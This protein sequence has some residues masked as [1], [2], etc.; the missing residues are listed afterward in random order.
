[1]VHARTNFARRR[2]GFTLIELILALFMASI[3]IVSLTSSLKIAYQ[4]KAAADRN[5]E[6]ARTADIAMELLR[7][8]FQCAVEPSASALTTTYAYNIS[9]LGSGLNSINLDV[10]TSSTTSGTT[11]GSTS[12]TTSGSLAGPFVGGSGNAL[13]ISGAADDLVFFTTADSPQHVDANSEIKQVEYTLQQINNTDQY[14]LVRMTT[15]NLLDPDPID[16]VPPDVEYLCRGV[17]AFSCQ[18]YDGQDWNDSWDSTENDNDLPVAVQVTLALDR[19][20]QN[21]PNRVVIFTRVFTLPCSGATFD[22]SINPIIGGA[23][24]GGGT[25]LGGLSP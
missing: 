16:D 9:S 6:P 21:D 4:A 17:A 1:M 13:N 12:S 25:T 24:D 5:L 19:P 14:A 8:D 10:S 7:N 18:Y 22:S 15:R 23:G 2:S 20:T 11:S 3:L